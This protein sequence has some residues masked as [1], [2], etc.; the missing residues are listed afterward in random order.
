MEPSNR[1]RSRILALVRL[2]AERRVDISYT[3]LAGCE[4]IVRLQRRDTGAI[5]LFE[6]AVRQGMKQYASPSEYAPPPAVPQKA[7]VVVRVSAESG[8]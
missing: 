7:P 1:N 3:I 6:A 5:A 4:V 2:W 8:T